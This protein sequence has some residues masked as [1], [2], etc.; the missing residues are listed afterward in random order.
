MALRA[1]QVTVSAT[2]VMLTVAD[3]DHRDGSSI[4]VQAPSGATLYIGGDATVSASTGWPV[5]A[6]QSLALDLQAGEVVYGVLMTGTDTAYVL[7][8]GV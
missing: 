8:S 6:G 1:Q 5:A 4:A 3:L 2:P 7:R